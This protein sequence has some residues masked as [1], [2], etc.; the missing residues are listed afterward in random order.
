MIYFHA[1]HSC[2]LSEINVADVDKL[3]VGQY[4]YPASD[5]DVKY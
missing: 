2:N 4:S 1:E 3:D 5:A